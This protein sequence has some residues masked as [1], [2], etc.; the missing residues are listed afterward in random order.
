MNLRN[1]L[2]KVNIIQEICENGQKNESIAE[3]IIYIQ[4]KQNNQKKSDLYPI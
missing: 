4:S 2:L 1:R 3:H